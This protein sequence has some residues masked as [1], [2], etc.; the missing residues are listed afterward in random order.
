MM[1]F[2]EIDDRF[3]GRSVKSANPSTIHLAQT[4]THSDHI[5]SICAQ[6]FDMGLCETLRGL[7]P[8]IWLAY[9]SS[10]IYIVRVCIGFRA[11]LAQRGEFLVT[12]Y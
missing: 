1:H 7:A 6:G 11:Y 10:H 12:L 2:D 4:Y 8:L 9:S 3:V 5:R